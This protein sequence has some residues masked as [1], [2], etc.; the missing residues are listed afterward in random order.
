M[1]LA[2]QSICVKLLQKYNLISPSTGILICNSFLRQE[3]S[4]R[5]LYAAATSPSHKYSQIS[6]R[7]V[8][9]SHSDKQITKHNKNFE[10]GQRDSSLELRCSAIVSR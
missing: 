10:Y 6:T 9:K 2:A 4:S 8:K 1:Q 5:R 7:L 3:K